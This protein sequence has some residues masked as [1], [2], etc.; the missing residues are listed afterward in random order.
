MRITKKDTLP[1]D[2]VVKQIDESIRN[3]ITDIRIM[4]LS[5]EE[6]Q[7][8]EESIS[9]LLMNRKLKSKQLKEG[10]YIPKPLKSNIEMNQGDLYD[11]IDSV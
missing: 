8:K 2:Q 1:I 7:K 4:D 3:H 6:V 5:E 9:L 10:A 11:L